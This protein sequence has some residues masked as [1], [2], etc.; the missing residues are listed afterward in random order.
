MFSVRQLTYPDAL[1]VASAMRLSDRREIAATRGPMLMDERVAMDCYAAH[2]YGGVGYVAYW[3][4]VPV[5]AI[6]AIPR[7]PGVWSIY[8]FA[9][10]NISEIGLGLTRW[11]QN[12]LLPEITAAGA[13]R[14]ECNSIEGHDVAHAWMKVFGAKNEGIMPKFGIGQEN[15]YRFALTGD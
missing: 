9:T 8:M 1:Y 2:G 7:H 4:E 5:V 15:F 13:H 14:I 10:D 3:D 12:T 11:V 6:G